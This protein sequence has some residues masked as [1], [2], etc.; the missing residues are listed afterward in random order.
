MKFVKLA[1]VI[2][3]ASS[4]I[5]FSIT[6]H[7]PQFKIWILN[8]LADKSFRH[9][10]VGVQA[11]SLS[12]SLLPLG[13]SLKN[14]RAIPQGELSKV[15]APVYCDEITIELHWLRLLA[16]YL[17]ASE[18]RILHPRV[19]AI[20]PKSSKRSTGDPIPFATIIGRVLEL[21]IYKLVVEDMNLQIRDGTSNLRTRIGS[22]GIRITNRLHSLALEIATEDLA[23]KT[24]EQAN[25]LG[26]V[27]V[28]LRAV[29]NP[30]LASL[31]SLK[32]ARDRSYLIASGQA[33]GPLDFLNQ[34]EL[35]ADAKTLIGA[36][37]ARGWLKTL[38]P[39]NDFPDAQGFLQM[40]TQVRK[41]RGVAPFF[42]TQVRT[43]QLKVDK[44]SL[45]RVFANAT[46]RHPDLQIPKLQVRNQAGLLDVDDVKVN[47]DARTFEGKVNPKPLEIGALLKELGLGEI[48]IHILVNGQLPC[49]GSW[50]PQFTSACKGALDVRDLKIKDPSQKTIVAIDQVH[51]EGEVKVDSKGVY[52]QGL[53]RLKQSQGLAKGQVLFEDGF[54]F[55]FSTEKLDFSDIRD[56]SDLKL[57]GS[58]AIK[59]RT[60]GNSSVGTV[61]IEAQGENLWLEDFGLGS[62]T[63]KVNYAAGALNFSD[64]VG[65]Y[66]TTRYEGQVSLDLDKSQIRGNLKFPIVES[67]DIQ[68]ALSRKVELPFE[69]VSTGEAS[70]QFSG[71]LDFPKL[72][73]QLRT[74]LYRGLIGKEGFDQ[75]R[76]DVNS[77]G[78]QVRTESAFL[79]KGKGRIDLN[80][81][82]QSSGQIQGTITATGL[83][84]EES[85]FLQGTG[86]NLSGEISGQIKLTDY[87]PKPSL[88]LSART[89]GLLIGAEALPDSE[90]AMKI[91]SKAFSGEAEVLGGDIR[92]SFRFPFS[93]DERFRFRL[94]TKSWNFAPLIALVSPDFNVA[95]YDSELTAQIDLQAEKGGF[96]NS[97]G[98]IR[99]ETLRVQRGTVD[100]F[101]PLPI[102]AR[103]EQGRL[104]IRNFTLQGDD[105]YF[106]VV[107]KESSRDSLDLKLNG[108]VDMGL[109]AFLL[110]FLSD[111][112]GILSISTQIS[113]SVEAPKVLGTAYLEKG[114]A[115]PKTLP[116][117]IEDIRAEVDFTQNRILLS[118][119][120]AR[121]AGGTADCQGTIELNGFSNLPAKIVGEFKN[122]DLRVPNGV[123]SRGSGTFEVFGNWFPYTFKAAYIVTSGLVSTTFIEEEVSTGAVRRS[124]LLPPVVIRREFEPFLFDLDIRFPKPID[125]KNIFFDATVTGQ[126]S[127]KGTPTA[128][129]ILGE[130]NAQE[131]GKLFFRDVPFTIASASLKFTDPRETNPSVYALANAQVRDRLREYQVSMLV[132]G[133]VRSNQILLRSQP[134]LPDQEIISLLALGFTST[135]IGQ[136]IR[137][138]D[139]ASRQSYELGSAILSK[140]PLNDELKKRYGVDVRFSSSID[141]LNNA[142]VSKIV[143]NKQWTPKLGTSASRTIGSKIVQDVKLEYLLNNN[144]SVIGSWEGRGFDEEVGDRV[145]SLNFF[146]LDLQYKVDF[147]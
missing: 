95:E 67:L 92:T 99:I 69:I 32:I 145:E 70:V 91:D 3:L 120:E 97:T 64:I 30:R 54:D 127:I 86:L 83:R 58:S 143:L 4:L 78:N 106:Q 55:T 12:I 87:L 126:L 136:D 100:F 57:Q 16:G 17:E 89:T 85:E 94:E 141:R 63:A 77:D 5:G 142:A 139:Q 34:V 81:V 26:S 96:W 90:V 105:T 123:A 24:N 20:L 138:E 131:K 62:T 68:E 50:A 11:D 103:M 47:V 104:E 75:I 53:I 132:Q 122:V 128:P 13:V 60:R 10:P 111:L 135:D 88:D 43:V 8:E 39:E 35:E 79:K 51:I 19:T 112:R 29:L 7:L 125:V 56:L 114:F 28:A 147:K 108:K 66:R 27:V 134:P 107:G 18:I 117:A 46:Y 9:S 93:S 48:P 44:F 121:L 129:Q 49:Q 38:L 41:G 52:P 21:P 72:T 6:Y 76:F 37:E 110:P 36:S 1:V 80:A 137:R 115:K 2:G 101:A 146:G 140:N 133:T 144:V 45:G 40:R 15:L 116:H 71:P 14:I 33:Q 73:Y 119:M 61:D 65:R 124:S 109:L 25:S 84:L 23:V 22:L 42:E 113:G 118:K 31:T 74:G 98:P 130:V 82:A 102:D 59:G